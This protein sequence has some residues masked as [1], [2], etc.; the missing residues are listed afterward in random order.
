M[1]N[2]WNRL[3]MLEFMWT[4]E[5]SIKT[6]EL[7]T[8]SILTLPSSNQEKKIQSKKNSSYRISFVGDYTWVKGLQIKTSPRL[9]KL[10]VPFC[11]G[12]VVFI[13]IIIAISHTQCA[14]RWDCFF[15]RTRSSTKYFNC[16]KS[17]EVVYRDQKRRAIVAI[18][19]AIRVVV[20]NVIIVYISRLAHAI[21]QRIFFSTAR[22]RVR[23]LN[24]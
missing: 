11:V 2:P 22:A 8:I 14:P 23:V 10:F 13:V 19:I 12:A 20:V 5:E 18:F 9:T 3:L 1:S 16:R 7:T 4:L 15:R 6:L 21:F 24:I 17:S